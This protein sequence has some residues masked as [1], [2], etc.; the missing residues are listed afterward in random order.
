VLSPDTRRLL[1]KI[2][3]WTGLAIGLWIVL[4]SLT[5]LAIVWR[6][7][8]DRLL[9]PSLLRSSGPVAIDLQTALDRVRA[10]APQ[11]RISR[12]EL[13]AY[14][15]GVY[16]AWLG[17]STSLA[18][19]IAT[20]D[21]ATGRVLGVVSLG[22]LPGELLFRLHYAL[23]AGDDG[24]LVV[25]VL[26]CAYFLFLLITGL[27]LWWPGRA[28]LKTGFKMKLDVGRARALLDLHRVIGAAAALVLL[29]LV[30]TGALTALKP[31]LQAGLAL[32]NL[33]V[34]AVA[35]QTGAAL[36]PADT[37]VTRAL[38]VQP[39]TIARD[40]RFAGSAGQ[41]VTVVLGTK[42]GQAAGRV[43]LNGYDG[44]VLTSYDHSSAPP[45]AAVPETILWLHK[46]EFLGAA[47]DFVIAAAALVP[48]LLAVT[49]TWMWL[50][51]R[52]S[53]RVRSTAPRP[54]T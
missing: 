28:R 22:S 8:L 18:S 17:P 25:G 4:Q 49:G 40:V 51:R 3:R 31:Q 6:E 39:G 11:P 43:Y 38:A 30:A 41:S 23:V 12:I 21:A 9:V 53:R 47:G 37:F 48:L 34:P 20:V 10:V 14:A 32:R 5:G 13:P 27:L 36:Q 42:D 15:D 46:G 24:R 33:V 35:A 1:V 16:R 50:R 54:V 26:G 7:D 2:H 44:S 45:A 19:K 29:P 52:R